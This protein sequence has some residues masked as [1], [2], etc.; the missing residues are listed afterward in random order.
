[1]SERL[2]FLNKIIAKIGSCRAS[3]EKDEHK[4]GEKAKVDSVFGPMLSY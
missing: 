2:S 4:E 3:R 1:M